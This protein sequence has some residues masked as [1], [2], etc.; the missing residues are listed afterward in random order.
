MTSWARD[1]RLAL[2]D[3]LEQVGPE[4]PT[5]CAGWATRDLAAHLVLRERRPLSAAG[6][7]LRPLSRLTAATQAQLRGEHSYAELLDLLRAGPPA[8]SPMSW[9]DGV[10]EA[11]NAAEFFVHHEDVRRASDG[12]AP[13]P[14]PGRAEALLWRRLRAL[15]RPLT[16]RATVGVTFRRPDGALAPGRGGSRTVTVSGAPS[17]LLLFA[18]GRADHAKVDFDGEP[19][20]VQALQAAAFGL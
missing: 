19:A 12:W 15:A 7:V 8:W 4:A 5:L 16:R 13:R 3:L 9:S 18:F 11:A 17:E 2:A 6:I 10:E 1:E 20:A 14:L